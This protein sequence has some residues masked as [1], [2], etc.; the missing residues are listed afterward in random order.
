[1][2]KTAASARAADHLGRSA[3]KQARIPTPCSENLARDG[4]SSVVQRIH[5]SKFEAIN[6]ESVREVVVK[7]F[8]GDRGLRDSEAAE[9]SG[10]HQMSVHRTSERAVMRD[11]IRS[12]GVNRYARRHRRSPGRVGARVE[13]GCEVHGLQLAVTG[14]TCTEADERRV[15]LG[16]RNNRFR[17]RINHAHGLA[18]M[19]CGQRNE[20][21]H[22]KIKLGAEAAANSGWND[23]HRLWRDA[24]NSGNVGTIHVRGLGAGLNLDLIVDAPGEAGFGLNVGVLD[25]AGLVFILNHHIGFRQ[26]LFH[27][28]ADHAAPDQHVIFPAGMDA[29]GIRSERGCNRSQR[30]Q[31]FP[32]DG[33][34]CEVE[35]LDGLGLTHH[36]GDGLAAESGFDLGKYRLVCETRNHAVAILSRNVCGGQNAVDSG[37]RGDEGREIAEAEASTL[38]R[39]AD[40]ANQQ[41]CGRNLVRAKDLCAIHLALAVEP[42][43]P[44]PTALPARGDGSATAPEQ[45]SCIAEMILR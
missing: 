1:M 8:L 41:R 33:E 13:V 12:R 4:R 45:A 9:S 27:V 20:G 6:R 38:V 37:M 34:T 44:R 39:A 14:R 15:T 18:E 29:F 26:G 17:A 40:G 35:S 28:A 36:G 32:C 30:G 31:G 24:K 19:P 11:V 5:D 25:K 21:L 23:A 22:R 7:L 43:Q 10:R 3:S 16:G 2:L 42:D